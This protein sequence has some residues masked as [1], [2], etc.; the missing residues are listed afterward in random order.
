MVEAN[1]AQ[2]E[3]QQIAAADGNKAASSDARMEEEKQVNSAETGSTSE[4]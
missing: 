1:P 3:A 4:Q 2:T